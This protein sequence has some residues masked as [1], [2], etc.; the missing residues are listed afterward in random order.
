MA[1]Q[2]P[3]AKTILVVDD[4][5]VILKLMKRHLSSLGYSVVTAE[6]GEEALESMN[7]ALPQLVFLDIKMPGIGGIECLKLMVKQHPEVPVV[8][9]T[10]VLDRDT[11][12]K[13][14]DGGAADYLY[15]PMDLAVVTEMVARQLSFHSPS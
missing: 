1:G 3:S 13:A 7:K 9:L 4:E 11:A 5:Q 6:S 8:M 10:A 2:E 14:I 12:M 15:K